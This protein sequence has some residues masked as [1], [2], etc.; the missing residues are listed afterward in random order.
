MNVDLLSKMVRDV[1]LDKDEVSLHG[2]GS[3]VAEIVPSTFSD[4]GYTINPPYRRLFFR[5][6]E[7]PADTS[8]VDLY[9]KSNNVDKE[10]AGRILSE[11]FTEMRGILETRK[12]I[13]LPGLGKLRATRENNFFFVADENLDIYPEGFGLEPISLKTHQETSEEISDKLNELQAIMQGAVAET[14]T[15]ES[16]ET[17]ATESVPDEPAA[18][19]SETIPSEL[20]VAE[21][22]NVAETEPE[23][24]IEPV[25]ETVTETESVEV[26][27]SEPEDQNEVSEVEKEAVKTVEVVEVEPAG[28]PEVGQVEP[29]EI[30]ESAAAKPKWPK[31]LKWGSIIAVAAVITALLAFIALAKLSP[32]FVD[33]LLYTPEELEIINY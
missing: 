12:N 33:S 8:L 24:V 26:P 15:S 19:D 23:P 9:C 21:P 6:K 17:V 29:A 16:N 14:V 11:F 30:K 32:D 27:Y 20:V 2:V 25:S 4:K 13:V 1:I 31:Y 18:A 7:N 10:T 3:F 5:Q 28:T 22:E